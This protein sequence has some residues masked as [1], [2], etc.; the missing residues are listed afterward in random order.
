MLNEQQIKFIKEYLKCKLNLTD[1]EKDIIDT[2]DEYI[3][4]PLNIRQAAYRIKI[5]EIKYEDLFVKVNSLPTTIP[6]PSSQ[7]TDVDLR[8]LLDCQLSFLYQKAFPEE[9][10]NDQTENANA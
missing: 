4:N 9:T 1:L 2:F 6:K 3:K 8:Y 5:N 7:V 10:N